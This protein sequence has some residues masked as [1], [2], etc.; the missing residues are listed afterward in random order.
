MNYVVVKSSIDTKGVTSIN[1][2]Y[3]V[4]LR[5]GAQLFDFNVDLLVNKPIDVTFDGE[6]K[7]MDTNED[8]RLNVVIN[9]G[10]SVGKHILTLVSPVTGEK[11][12]ITVNIL[13]RIV[14]NANVNMYYYDGHVYKVRVRDNMGNFVCK[15]QIVTFKIGK[16]TFKVRTDAKGYATLKIPS[17]ITPGKYTI[18]ATF[19]G[20]TVKNKLVVKQVLKLTKVKVKKSSKKLILKATLKNGSKALKSKKVT[21]KF[22]G[23]KYTAKTNKKG[24][25]KVTIKSKVLKKLKVGKKVKYQVTYLKNTVKRTVKVKR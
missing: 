21:F 4:K 20:Q 2:G 13:S 6:T 3:N 15:N 9:P 7:K 1:I 8:G 19:A 10:N 16:K 25:A 22:N 11:L 24:L 5:I 17:T 23:K 12:S 14:G 18:S